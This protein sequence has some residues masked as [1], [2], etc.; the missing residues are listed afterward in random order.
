MIKNFLVLSI[1]LI[2]PL[3]S[4]GQ[5]NLVIRTGEIYKKERFDIVP[6]K[7]IGF[8]VNKITYPSDGAIIYYLI[9]DGY[10]SNETA[11]DKSDVESLLKA[12]IYIRD[13]ALFEDAGPNVSYQYQSDKDFTIFITKTINTDWKFTLQVNEP[14]NINVSS[15][16]FS[17]SDLP[18]FIKNLQLALEI[19]N[20]K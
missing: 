2:L 11:I 6:F 13:T 1:F 15:I 17:K 18:L 3:L 4:F 16:T 20:R 12:M 9:I 5:S 19:M 8:Y 10:F 7:G 14:L